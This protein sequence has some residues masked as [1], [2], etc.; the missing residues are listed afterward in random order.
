[1]NLLGA[2]QQALGVP[3]ASVGRLNI[4]GGGAP[5]EWMIYCVHPIYGTPAAEAVRDALWDLWLAPLVTDVSM[6]RAGDG[7]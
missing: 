6:R 1:M 3:G 4:T 2:I 5:H 7:F